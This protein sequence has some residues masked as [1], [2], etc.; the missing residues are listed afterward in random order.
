MVDVQ[1]L[2]HQTFFSYRNVP[3]EGGEGRGV[4]VEDGVK[5]SKA[6]RHIS[7][8]L[9]CHNFKFR[10]IFWADDT[11]QEEIHTLERSKEELSKQRELLEQKLQEGSLLD[12]KEER[13]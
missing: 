12:P 3:D 10:F 4:T 11:K 8:R 5:P 6:T 9:F 7:H 1:S 2:S 13:R